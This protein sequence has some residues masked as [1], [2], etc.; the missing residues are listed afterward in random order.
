MIHRMCVAEPMVTRGPFILRLNGFRE[1]AWFGSSGLNAVKT[2]HS[3][4]NRR[5]PVGEARILM[6]AIIK[7]IQEGWVHLYTVTWA[8]QTVGS[9]LCEVVAATIFLME[10]FICFI[11]ILLLRLM[12]LR[13]KKHGHVGV[14]QG[15]LC[16]CL[17][18]EVLLP[19]CGECWIRHGGPWG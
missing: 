14:W 5:N 6:F 1:N 17:S 9:S 18:V 15:V 12:P 7:S 19:L 10:F 11:V 13:S 16:V 4:S 2:Y 8:T 3:Y